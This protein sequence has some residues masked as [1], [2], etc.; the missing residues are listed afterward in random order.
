MKNETTRDFLK[1][2]SAS[3]SGWADLREEIINED[4]QE[5][6]YRFR[7]ALLILAFIRKED[8]SKQAFAARVGWK[9]QYLSRVLKCKQDLKLSTILK[10]QRT[11]GSTVIEIAEEVF[12]APDSVRRLKS[13]PVR[14]TTIVVNIAGQDYSRRN[15]ESFSSRRSATFDLPRTDGLLYRSSIEQ[16][17]KKSKGSPVPADVNAIPGAIAQA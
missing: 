1:Q 15:I 6:R 3:A 17:I 8:I 2:T 7:I 11:I 10:I 4:Q 12:A 9:P 5:R 16:D 14:T 13:R